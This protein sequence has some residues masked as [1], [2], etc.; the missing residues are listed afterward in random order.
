MYDHEQGERKQHDPRD[1]EAR[2]AARPA[3]LPPLP[4]E[5]LRDVVRAGEAGVDRGTSHREE[6]SDEREEEAD[7][8]ERHLRA[9]R[10]RADELRLDA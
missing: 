2:R 5:V 6:D 4:A 8:A 7:L 1:R 10:D 3:V 9:Q